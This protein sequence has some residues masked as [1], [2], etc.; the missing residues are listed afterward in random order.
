MAKYRKPTLA[1]GLA[2]A[3]ALTFS[4]SG[5]GGG[6]P[7]TGTSSENTASSSSD[8][9]S[10]GGSSSSVSSSSVVSSSSSEVSSSSSI[11]CTGSWGEWLY[12]TSPIGCAE[13]E[14]ARIC[15]TDPSQVE[16]VAIP[17][18]VDYDKET[19]FCQ[20][21]TNEVKDLC[22]GKAYASTQFCQAGTNVVLP[23]CGTATYTA[24]QMC[25]YGKEKNYFTDA[26]DNKKYPYVTIGTQTWMAENLNY[27]ASGSK[28]GDGNYLSDANTA[29]CDTYG[30]LYDW[31]TAMNNSASSSANPSGRQGVC[32]SGWHIPSNAEWNALMKSVNSACSDNNNCTVAGTKLKAASGWNPYAGVPAGTD[33]FGFSALPGGYGSSAS[34]YDVGNY[35]IWW[36][37]TEND[38]SRAYYR[39]MYFSG[40]DVGWNYY[41]NSHLYSVRCAKD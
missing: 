6:E 15:K 17:A 37:S 32:P 31:A 12:I 2:L 9:S 10:S 25:H 7:P 29:T 21:V 19:Q 27:N 16:R 14:K 40:A 41:D 1:A 18:P 8:A 22:G 26:R 36:S 30:R 20:A 24:E 28:C 38:A 34:F 39:Y 11:D 33:E 4:C 13:G 3:A 5:D 35:G 23:L